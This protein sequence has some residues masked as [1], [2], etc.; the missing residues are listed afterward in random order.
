MQGR[1]DFI[2][3]NLFTKIPVFKISRFQL[4]FEQHVYKT[5]C[6]PCS[7][8]DKL[9]DCLSK[10]CQFAEPCQI[11]FLFFADPQLLTIETKIIPILYSGSYPLVSIETRSF[12]SGYYPPVTIETKTSCYGWLTTFRH[13]SQYFKLNSHSA[14]CKNELFQSVKG[15]LICTHVRRSNDNSIKYH[16]S[17]K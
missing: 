7:R 2:Y 10:G 3:G 14:H 17:N 4:R 15:C 13:V 16:I 8:R 11:T 1:H 6:Q 9:V 12:L 5:S